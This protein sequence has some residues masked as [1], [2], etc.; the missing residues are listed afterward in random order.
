[1]VQ[2][3]VGYSPQAGLLRVN[4]IEMTDMTTKDEAALDLYIKM[5]LAPDPKK[6]TKVPVSHPPPS[7][8][9]ACATTC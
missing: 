8:P 4:V 9:R 2:L 1:M 5:F 6:A 3:G 7:P